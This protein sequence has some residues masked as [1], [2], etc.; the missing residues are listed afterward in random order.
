[1]KFLYR[2][3]TPESKN[4][5]ATIGTGNATVNLTTSSGSIGIRK[6]STP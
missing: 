4:L 5:A 1:M 2:N 3:E 6:Q